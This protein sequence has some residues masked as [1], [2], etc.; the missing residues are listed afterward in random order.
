M[1]RGCALNNNTVQ[2]QTKTSYSVTQQPTLQQNFTKSNKKYITS[3]KISQRATK[4][5]LTATTLHK[6]Q[7][8]I[9]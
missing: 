3:N 1:Q 6:E 8:K 9:Y 5:I 7:Q 4:N 2:A